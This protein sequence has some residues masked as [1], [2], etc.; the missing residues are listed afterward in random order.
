MLWFMFLGAGNN[1]C[2]GS[3]VGA[4][5]NVRFFCVDT[6]NNVCFGFGFLVQG[7]KCALVCVF[8]GNN[9]C[10]ALCRCREQC[11]LDLAVS[12]TG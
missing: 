7:T 3:C 6:G 9:V 4:G 11:V 10:F 2:F 8:A 5:N 12:K 1:V